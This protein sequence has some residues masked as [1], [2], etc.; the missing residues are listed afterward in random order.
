MTETRAHFSLNRSL[1][2]DFSIYL[3]AGSGRH[4]QRD[5]VT[6]SDYRDL[7]AVLCVKHGLHIARE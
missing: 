4:A 3:W 6:A 7:C 5:G 2:K 1:E